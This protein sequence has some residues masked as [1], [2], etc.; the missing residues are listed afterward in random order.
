MDN[1]N[2]VLLK[3]DHLCQYFRLGRK[4]LKAVDDVSFEIKRGEAFGAALLLLLLTS[5]CEHVNFE[6]DWAT[7]AESVVDC[8]HAKGEGGSK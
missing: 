3:V 8:F 2:E 1:N 5:G 4:D 7:L 6:F